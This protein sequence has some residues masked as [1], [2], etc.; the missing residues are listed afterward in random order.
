MRSYGNNCTDACTTYD[1]L[2]RTKDLHRSI[3]QSESAMTVWGQRSYSQEAPGVQPLPERLTSQHFPA[4]KQTT[5][6]TTLPQ[7]RT[8]KSLSLVF[9]LINLP[10]CFEKIDIPLLLA[11]Q[12]YP[13]GRPHPASPGAKEVRVKCSVCS[14]YIWQ[15]QWRIICHHWSNT[16]SISLGTWKACDPSR[17]LNTLSDRKYPV[18]INVLYFWSCFH[19]W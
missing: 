1:A 5:K 10:Y 15:L 13:H 3:I 4:E 11:S 16:H 6:K 14:R 8:A 2:N 18:I 7:L 19:P 12:E 17:P 9:V